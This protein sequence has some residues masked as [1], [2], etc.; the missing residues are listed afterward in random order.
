MIA[1][2]LGVHRT[3]VH[4]V[5]QGRAPAPELNW[6]AIRTV[7]VAQAEACDSWVRETEISHTACAMS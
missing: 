2:V 6:A 3:Y 1:D 7:Q 4:Q 5:V